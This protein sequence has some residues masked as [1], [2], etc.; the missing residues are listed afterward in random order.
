MGCDTLIQV[1]LFTNLGRC[2]TTN[3]ICIHEQ[4]EVCYRVSLIYN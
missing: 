3:N 2:R 4:S 1:K